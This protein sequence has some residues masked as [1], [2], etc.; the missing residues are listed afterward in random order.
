MELVRISHDLRALY[1]ATTQ[2]HTVTV[3]S[4]IQIH[5]YNGQGSGNAYLIDG[6]QW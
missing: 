4:M 6:V 3:A 1:S 2:K 5:R